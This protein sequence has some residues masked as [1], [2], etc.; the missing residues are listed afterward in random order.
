MPE[1][2][3]LYEKKDHVA[4][5]TL[6]RPAKM[7]AYNAEVLIKESEIWADFRDDP[8][9]Y[10]AIL[11][12]AGDQAFCAGG[13]MT[14]MSTIRNDDSPDSRIF[15]IPL[16]HN[17]DLRIMKPI[18]G[19]INGYCL[20]GGL[21]H[22]LH[23]D[24][25]IASENATFGYQQVRYA[26]SP[27]WMGPARLPHEIGLSNTL[28]LLLTGTRID[29]Q[30]ALRMCLIHKIVPQKDLMAAA[31]EMAETLLMN[32]PSHMAIKKDSIFRCLSLPLEEAK[33]VSWFQEGKV[34]MA[35]SKE[36]V[37]SFLEKR[38]PDWSKV[39]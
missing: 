6:N 12:G 2:V 20:S 17:G 11:T 9:L 4:I 34:P 35:E 10:V 31:F 39:I 28:Y 33:M 18:I 32:S 30:E 19:A 23:T 22:A 7:N 25:R 3:V 1:P 24:I 37:A 26:A 13:D 29:A 21:T 36:G 8:N 14:M 15:R 5:I 38:K 16:F 27:S